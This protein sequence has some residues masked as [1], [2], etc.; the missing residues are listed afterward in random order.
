MVFVPF[1]CVFVFAFIFGLFL[2]FSDCSGRKEGQLERVRVICL[3]AV[4]LFTSFVFCPFLRGKGGRTALFVSVYVCVRVRMCVHV[5]LVTIPNIVYFGYITTKSYP[6][7]HT[8]FSSAEHHLIPD[9][10]DPVVE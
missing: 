4:F 7:F 3:M 6:T 2:C 9:S 10:I 5:C 8:F 1:Y